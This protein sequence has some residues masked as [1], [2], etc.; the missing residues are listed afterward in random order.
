MYET[1]ALNK[2][3]VK[4]GKRNIITSIKPLNNNYQNKKGQ[5]KTI[6]KVKRNLLKPLNKNQYLDVKNALRNKGK[7]QTV[8]RLKVLSK[9]SKGTYYE[10]VIYEICNYVKM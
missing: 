8:K 4:V 7:N 9:T 6:Y 5:N 10:T 1:Q 3:R 2:N